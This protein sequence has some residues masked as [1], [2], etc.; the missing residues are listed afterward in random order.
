MCFVSP[1]Q[2]T[3]KKAGVSSSGRAQTNI[4][5]YKLFKDA[6]MYNTHMWG[7]VQV[8][9]SWVVVVYCGFLSRMIQKQ[10]YYILLTETK[11]L[12]MNIPESMCN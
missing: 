3:S 8:V 5:M 11:L 9:E 2:L 1:T 4:K 12:P 10:P 6:W 7:W